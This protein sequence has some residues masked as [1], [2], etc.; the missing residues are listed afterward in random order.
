MES[1]LTN[2]VGNLQLFPYLVVFTQSFAYD[3]NY[4]MR[5]AAIVRLYCPSKF[6]YQEFIPGCIQVI[7]V[8]RKQSL[9]FYGK[10]WLLLC[11]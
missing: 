6:L 10:L 11:Y 8:F 7:Y 5:A 2:V 9:V 3:Q 4:P 1:V